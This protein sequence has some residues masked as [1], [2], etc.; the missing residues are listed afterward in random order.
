[1]SNNEKCHENSVRSKREQK[2]LKRRIIC[3]EKTATKKNK[4][5]KILTRDT[6]Q[7]T[8]AYKILKK[9]NAQRIKPAKRPN[10]NYFMEAFSFIPQKKL[11]ECLSSIKI[12][13]WKSHSYNKERQY[14]DFFK[15]FI[16]PYYIPEPLLLITILKDL[17]YTN[18]SGTRDKSL[19]YD[20]IQLSKKWI[21]DIVNGESFYKVNKKYFTK[22][23]AHFFLCSKV[24]Y[25]DTWSVIYIFFEAKCKARNIP[26]SFCD[27]IARV[28]S[29]KF[30]Q[31]L[32]NVILTSFLDL[33]G[34]YANDIIIENEFGDICDF[35]L[36]EILRYKESRNRKLPFSCSGRTLQSVIS[37][38]NEW[39]IQVQRDASAK[40]ELQSKSDKQKNEYWK[41]FPIC[42][43][44][45]EN[46]EFVWNINQ[47]CTFNDLVNEG[48]NMKHCVASYASCCADGI[49]AIFH[50][51]GQRKSDKT[52]VISNATVEIRTANRAIVQI[53]GKCNARVD[54]IT[55]NVI[56]RWAQANNLKLSLLH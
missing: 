12:A 49:T 2:R 33:L 51:S 36:S 34:R 18:T 32:D 41:N 48:R 3:N 50:V 9:D 52:V 23:E 19:D 46:D 53:K 16:Y 38:A 14:L 28:F 21:C 4:K 5:I 54:E 37:L 25:I 20:I 1:M 55:L 11:N 29:V 6:E 26:D 35:I 56:K 30:S 17:H 39:H 42:N 10:L 15:E 24:K 47:L 8:V 22:R 27:V 31:Y 13:E 44:L 40:A 45:F 7:K 43:F